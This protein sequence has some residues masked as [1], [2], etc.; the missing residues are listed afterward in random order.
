MTEMKVKIEDKSFDAHGSILRGLEFS[1]RDGEFIALVGPSGAG[2]STLLNILAGLDQDYQ[3][4]IRWGDVDLGQPEAN[5]PRLGMLFQEPRLMPWLS[6]LDNIN[7]VMPEEQGQ[8]D[9]ANKLL[10]DVGLSEWLHAWPNQL[11][12]GM[13]RRAALARAFAV[14]PQLLLMDEPFVSLDLPTA[15]RLREELIRLWEQEKPLVVFVTHDLREALAMADRILFMSS[16]PARVV[17]DY[18]VPA[19]DS[20]HIESAEIAGLQNSLLAEHPGLLSGLSGDEKGEP[21]DK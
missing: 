8:L 5:R 17:L 10:A 4:S 6:V 7:L 19:H 1:A 2:K 12:G 21:H 20:R 16:S 13:Q 14:S 9:K 18:Q 15:T 11:S 3:G